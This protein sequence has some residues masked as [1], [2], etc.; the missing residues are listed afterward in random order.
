MEADSLYAESK[1]T[2]ASEMRKDPLS[3]RK[4]KTVRKDNA[5][6]QHLMLTGIMGNQLAAKE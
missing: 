3:K 6:A 2:I 1:A 5:A 4:L